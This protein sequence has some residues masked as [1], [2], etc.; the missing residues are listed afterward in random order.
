MYQASAQ[1]RKTLLRSFLRAPSP[2]LLQLNITSNS[3]SPVLTR[4]R[5]DAEPWGPW[6]REKPRCQRG[7]L[8]TQT[9]CS[10]CSHCNRK[11]KTME[12]SKSWENPLPQEWLEA[13]LLLT[14]KTKQRWHCQR[15]SPNCDS[16]KNSHSA[17]ASLVPFSTTILGLGLWVL[18]H[19]KGA[20]QDHKDSTPIFLTLNKN[21]T[22]LL[23]TKKSAAVWFVFF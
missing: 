16:H 3:V 15:V 17:G 11:V 20:V 12:F 7:T 9:R 18:C 14:S 8:H 22:K 2:F 23:I 10:S 21:K 13:K 5:A 4:K 6:G 1:Q 19:S